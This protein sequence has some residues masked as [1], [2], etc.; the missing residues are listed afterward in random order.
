MYQNDNVFELK[1]VTSNRLRKRIVHILLQSW[2][3]IGLSY[4]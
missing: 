3:T 4:N 1:F 2:F